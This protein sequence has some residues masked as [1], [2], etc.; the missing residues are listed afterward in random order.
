[1]FKNLRDTPSHLP[2]GIRARSKEQ[3]VNMESEDPKRSAVVIDI[4][5]REG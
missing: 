2:F 5:G 4:L 3:R 1:M